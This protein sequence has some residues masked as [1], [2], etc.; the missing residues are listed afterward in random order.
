MESGV[1]ADKYGLMWCA[2]QT[3][4]PALCR[5]AQQM[6]R[7]DHGDHRLAHGRRADADAGVV[8]ALGR[9]LG[10]VAVDVDRAAGPP[11]ATRGVL[12]HAPA[13]GPFLRTWPRYPSDAGAACRSGHQKG[14][15]SIASQ[16]QRARSILCGPIWITAPRMVTPAPRILRAIAPAATRLAV[17]RAEARPPPR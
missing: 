12:P 4:S 17:S 11:E 3:S 13:A 6:V 5:V 2:E 8:A 15:S 7:E 1:I 10:V 16:S 14:L 9:D